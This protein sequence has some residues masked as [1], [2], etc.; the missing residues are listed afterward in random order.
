MIHSILPVLSIGKAHKTYIQHTHI[1]RWIGRQDKRTKELVPA[2]V[3][4][5]SLSFFFRRHPSLTSVE[6]NLETQVLGRRQVLRLSQR[7]LLQ[8]DRAGG[9]T[10][11]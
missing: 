9:A 2:R 5:I 8:A 4:S 6:Q 10:I 3:P 1:H 7:S 11:D